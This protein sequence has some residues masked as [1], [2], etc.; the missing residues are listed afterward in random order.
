MIKFETPAFIVDK[1]TKFVVDRGTISDYL[2]DDR[3]NHIC[4][5]F[6]KH[7]YYFYKTD[8]KRY[9]VLSPEDIIK[10]D[11]IIMMPRDNYDIIDTYT[12]FYII[13]NLTDNT[14]YEE[15]IDSPYDAIVFNGLDPD[16]RELIENLNYIK[17]IKTTSS[18]SGHDGNSFY[19][20][21]IIIN[22]DRY[23][24]FLD[25]ECISKLFLDKKLYIAHGEEP[26]S[27]LFVPY[28]KDESKS[29]LLEFNDAVKKY[30]KTLDT[31]D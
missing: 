16:I 23:L 21:Y 13:K 29:V 30:I 2:D 9:N 3:G 19:V 15:L 17:G 11:M 22:I 7:T 31:N 26:Y 27:Y 10:D 5:S 25:S 14:R 4:F 12:P 1:E 18:C 20:E 6:D 28:N 24:K 8:Q